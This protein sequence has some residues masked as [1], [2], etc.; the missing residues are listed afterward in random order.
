MAKRGHKK[1]EK[2]VKTTR[3]RAACEA[4]A[5]APSDGLAQSNRAV[6]GLTERQFS[7]LLARYPA[8][9]TQL[10][11]AKELIRARIRVELAPEAINALAKDAAERS[12]AARPSIV[13]WQEALKAILYGAAGNALYE[14]VKWLT[15]HAAKRA[16][17]IRRA[18]KALPLGMQPVLYTEDSPRCPR[19][20]PDVDDEVESLRE[21]VLG[22]FATTLGLEPNELLDSQRNRPL[23]RVMGNIDKM[24]RSALFRQPSDVFLT[25]WAGQDFY[26]MRVVTLMRNR[27]LRPE[28]RVVA[29]ES[30]E[31]DLAGL[32]I[33]PAHFSVDLSALRQLDWDEYVELHGLHFENT[34]YPEMFKGF[35]DPSTED[36]E[37]VPG[38][39]EAQGEER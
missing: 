9:S 35:A 28:H 29:A 7:E 27:R 21:E 38:V 17:K 23:G 33:L 18:V 30:F 36:Y 32:G 39:I 5:K 22:K 12:V 6:I 34:L 16:R 10:S 19:D 24:V 1:T 2:R 37:T 3:G 25:H 15:V 8:T 31:A 26:T 14:L 20:L 11:V 4:R 13:W